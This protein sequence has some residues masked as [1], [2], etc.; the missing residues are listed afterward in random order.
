MTVITIYHNPNCSKSRETLNLVRALGIEPE[1]IEYLV[2]PPSFESLK[3]LIKKLG[4]ATRE[5][6]RKKE[7]PYQQN[8]LDD[9]ALTDDELL[10]IMTKHPILIERPIVVR[11]EKAIIGRPPKKVMELL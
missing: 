11:G 7:D 8:N 10:K 2:N 1:I 9:P 6:L 5:V 3:E 4:L